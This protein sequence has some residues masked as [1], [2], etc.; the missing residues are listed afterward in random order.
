MRFEKVGTA[1]ETTDG[2]CKTSKCEFICVF[3]QFITILF[4]Q[5]LVV[6]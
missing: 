3:L 1:D 5:W 2:A 4:D 6:P